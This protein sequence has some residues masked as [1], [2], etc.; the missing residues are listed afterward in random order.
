MTRVVVLGTGIVGRAA[1]WDMLRRGYAVLVA[2]SDPA[3]AGALA[4]ELDVDWQPADASQPDSLA[5]LLAGSEL[6]ISAVPY[7]LGTGVAAAAVDAGVHY[8]DFGGNPTVVASQLGL[9]AAARRVGVAVVPD[10]GLAPGLANVL[11]E[12]DVSAV[13]PGTVDRVALRVGALP[14]EPTGALGYQL[15]FS[16]EGLVNE[17]AEP[18]EVLRD[19]SPTTVEPLTGFEEVDWEGWGPLEAFHTAGGSSSLAQRL[20]GRVSHLDYKTLRY[21]GHGRSF[22]AL[23]ELGMF[24]ETPRD[25]AGGRVSRRAVL[26]EALGAR[27]PSGAP[28]VVLVRTW[29]EA[30]RSGTRRFAGHQLVDLHDGRFSALARTT[31]FPATAL[32]HLIL[33]GS[34]RAAGARTMDAAVTADDLLAELGPVGIVPE[35]WAP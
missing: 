16:P 4:A 2:D 3:A 25:F 14:A 35:P 34:I 33:N 31:A 6:V 29:A 28:D 11:A 26:L 12:A 22:R 27:L 5:G 30:T 18:C 9:D 19:G 1:A 13:G 23:F 17:Y 32:A 15:A 10:C 24:D 8:L 7:R 20:Q 21:P